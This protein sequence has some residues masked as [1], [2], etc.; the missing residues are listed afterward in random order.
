MRKYNGGSVFGS[1]PYASE[2]AD[3]KA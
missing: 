2:G 1:H 3:E